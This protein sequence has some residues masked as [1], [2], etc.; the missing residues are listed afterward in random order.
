M[1]HSNF[2]ITNSRHGSLLWNVLAQQPIK[3]LIAAALP[4]SKWPCKVS[5]A[6]E[7]LINQSVRRKLFP[8]VIGQSLDPCKRVGLPLEKQRHSQKPPRDLDRSIGACVV[9]LND[10]ARF[11]RLSKQCS[12]ASIKEP[13]AVPINDKNSNLRPCLFPTNRSNR[14][15]ESL[16]NI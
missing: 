15:D 5:R 9:Q 6:V 12:Q 14:N 3:V 10:F 7:L 13:L 8:V 11:G 16:S 2:L 1:N 4:A